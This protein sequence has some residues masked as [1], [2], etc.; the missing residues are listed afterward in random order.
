MRGELRWGFLYYFPGWKRTCREAW[1]DEGWTYFNFPVPPLK[2]CREAPHQFPYHNKGFINPRFVQKLGC[3][4]PCWDQARLSSLVNKQVA[5]LV[6]LLIGSPPHANLTPFQ[7]PHLCQPPTLYCCNFWNSD[8]RVTAARLSSDKRRN[9][10]WHGTDP[11]PT[12]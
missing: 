3:Q 4:T 2:Q 12:L 9:K 5:P 11:L 1:R 6:A 7:N 8:A 10:G